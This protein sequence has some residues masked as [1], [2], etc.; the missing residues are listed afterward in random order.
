MAT[1][2]EINN[3]IEQLTSETSI[4]GL[5]FDTIADGM[6][7]S[8]ETYKAVLDGAETPEERQIIKNNYLKVIK[9]TAKAFIQQN[10]AIIKSSFNEITQGVLSLSEA[11]IA[12]T[13][14]ALMPPAIGAPPVAPN[15]AYV[16]LQN[17][18]KKNTLMITVNGLMKTFLGLLMAAV[19]IYFEVPDSIM[20]LLQTILSIKETISLIPIP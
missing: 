1:I 11:I 13:A 15:P 6:I 20:G 5:D 18:E 12:M 3:I 7:E 17:K 8:N 4:P 2:V 19:A 9:E 16:L 10:I 14:S